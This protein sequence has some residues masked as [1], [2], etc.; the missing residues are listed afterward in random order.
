ML[1]FHRT[2]VFEA[3]KCLACE[4]HFMF[5]QFSLRLKPALAKEA[6]LFLGET[7]VQK[8]VSRWCEFFFAFRSGLL[9]CLSDE[10]SEYTGCNK[11]ALFLGQHHWSL[12]KTTAKSFLSHWEVFWCHI[13]IPSSC[14]PQSTSSLTSLLR[15]CTPSVEGTSE[16]AEW[17]HT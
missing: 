13:A 12:I 16:A 8:P 17:G 9:F 3:W 10:I 4:G 6:S 1:P 11:S 14:S 5:C 2:A 7:Q 15:I